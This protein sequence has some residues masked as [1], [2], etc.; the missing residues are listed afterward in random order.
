MFFDATM[1]QVE[2]CVP[3]FAR[4]NALVDPVVLGVLIVEFCAG[5]IS[6]GHDPGVGL[7]TL[8]DLGPIR[9]L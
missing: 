5:D 8:F 3:L 1:E 9:F 7:I 2:E 4:S 6:I